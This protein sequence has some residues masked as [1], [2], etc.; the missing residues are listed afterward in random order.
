[1]FIATKYSTIMGLTAQVI[2]HLHHF[3][4]GLHGFGI[5]FVSALSDDH[6]DHFLDHFDVRHFEIALGEIAKAV[7][8]G[9]AQFGIPGCGRLTIQIAPHIFQTGWVGE[10]NQLNAKIL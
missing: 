5:H 6:V 2:A 10:S 8:P 7:F 1:M 4:G 3:V 9:I